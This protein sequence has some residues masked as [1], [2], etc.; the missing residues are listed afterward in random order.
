MDE[1]NRE[2]EDELK[3]EQV[4]AV[5][6]EVSERLRKNLELLEN[7]RKVRET[8][9]TILKEAKA[10]KAE[11]ESASGKTD[12]DESGTAGEPDIGAGCGKNAEA[13]QNEDPLYA[14]AVELVRSCG[15]VS[16]KFLKRRFSIGYERAVKLIERM[17][18]EGVFDP[19]YITGNRFSA[20][21]EPVSRGEGGGKPGEEQDNDPLYAAAVELIRRKNQGSTTLLQRMLSIGYGRAR[22]LVERMLAEG[23][24]D[25]GAITGG[26]DSPRGRIFKPNDPEE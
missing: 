15:F 12:A 9:E 14:A 20:D 16:T 11:N 2:N 17:K 6:K 1:R 18:A 19:L 13:L 22:K 3:P 5:L 24:I 10:R 7:L 23:I 25:S 4:Q 26:S 21:G 8:L